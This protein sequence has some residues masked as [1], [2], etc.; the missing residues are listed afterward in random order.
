ME[1]RVAFGASENTGA[2]QRAAQPELF[3]AIVGPV[4][5]ARARCCCLPGL[6]GHRAHLR[7]V[8]PRCAQSCNQF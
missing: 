3:T 2:R 8:A 7:R 6:R 5:A 1:S 4:Y